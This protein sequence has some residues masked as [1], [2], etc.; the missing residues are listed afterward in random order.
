MSNFIELDIQAPEGLWEEWIAIKEANGL[1]DGQISV[2]NVPGHEHDPLYGTGSLFY[3][4]DNRID[5]P[6]GSRT[7]PNFENPILETDF[8]SISNIFRG[9]NFESMI[10]EVRNRFTIG[11]GRIMSL[12]PHKCLSWHRDTEPR[13][14]LPLKTNEKCFMVIEDEVQH[15]S[16]NQWWLT[17][18]LKEHTAFNGSNEVRTHLVLC[19]LDM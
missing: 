8:T 16:A 7:V 9:T 3:D 14:H 15:L 17:D 18:T 19:V 10:N 13:L 11:R 5:H 12:S 2:T 4:W 6:D 1:T